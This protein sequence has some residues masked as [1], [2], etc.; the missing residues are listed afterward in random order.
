MILYPKGWTYYSLD[1][2]RFLITYELLETIIRAGNYSIMSHRLDYCMICVS[3]F[4][5]A[6]EGVV[7]YH[8]GL[9]QNFIKD[10]CIGE[11][12]DITGG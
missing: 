4:G 3:H 6:E 9:R 1:F 5:S 11:I 8:W 12:E 2:G 10:V 7:V